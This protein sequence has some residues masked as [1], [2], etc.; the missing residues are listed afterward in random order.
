M[1]ALDLFKSWVGGGAALS[2]GKLCKACIIDVST[3]AGSGARVPPKQ[4]IQALQR[5]AKYARAESVPVIAVLDG[6]E[7]RAAAHGAEFEGIK[8]LYADKAGSV[9]A[10]IQE[11]SRHQP[12]ALV[13]TDDKETEAVVRGKGV[14]TMRLSTFRKAIEAPRGADAA[15]GA[16]GHNGGRRDRRPRG[17][18]SRRGGRGE[19]RGPSDRDRSSQGERNGREERQEPTGQKE[20][21]DSVSDLIDLV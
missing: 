20:P 21:R 12:D 4:K 7:L 19:R 9:G 2:G 1:G 11:A 14:A 3:L 15:E 8:V 16:S 17:R 18:G 13:V 5:L 10:T 6:E